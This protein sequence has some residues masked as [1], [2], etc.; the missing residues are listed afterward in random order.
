M[1]KLYA[2]GEALIDFIPSERDAKLKEVTQF[3]PQVGGAPTNVASCVAKLG[4]NAAVVTQ[5]GDDAFGEKIEDK[6]KDVGVDTQYLKQT[7]T[8][9]TA[10]VFVS[11]TVAGERDFAFYRKPSADML[12]E[13]DQLTDLSFDETDILHFCSVDLVDCPMKA[14]HRMLID[15]M[16]EAKGTV[17]FDPNLR[18]PL[19][20]DLDALH[21]TVLEFIPKAHIV[22]ISDEELEFI[23]RLKDKQAAIDSLFKGNVEAVIYTEG[24]AGAALYTK[25]GL[26]AQET[27]FNVEVLDTTG[28][29]DAFIGAINY[30]LLTHGKHK[31][32]EESH[33]FLKFANAVGALTT[34]AYGAIESLPTK[35]QTTTFMRGEK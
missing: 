10:L 22:K 19:W 3:S 24:K 29:G 34:T 6:L 25:E 21:H 9:N 12:L 13:A 23:T 11:L 7:S 2:V 33:H 16:L 4:G 5:V 31:L 8:A 26:I 20:D 14:T 1:N 32:F 17:V 30:Q 15:Q 18:F 28:A 27:G 35:T